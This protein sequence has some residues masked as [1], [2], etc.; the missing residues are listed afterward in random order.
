MATTDGQLQLEGWNKNLPNQSN[1]TA[2][3]VNLRIDRATASWVEKSFV[4][5]VCVCVDHGR[6]KVEKSVAKRNFKFC[7]FELQGR[8]LSP[9]HYRKNTLTLLHPSTTIFSRTRGFIG[10]C[11]DAPRAFVVAPSKSTVEE[12]LAVRLRVPPPTLPVL[13]SSPTLLLDPAFSSAPR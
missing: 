1:A 9:L 4:A 7:S 3:C 11:L 12:P 2:E 10:R 5:R 8:T 6:R 13:P